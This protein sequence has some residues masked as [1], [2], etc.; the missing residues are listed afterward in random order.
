MRRTLSF[1]IVLMTLVSLGSCAVRQTVPRR[2]LTTASPESPGKFDHFST[3]QGQRVVGY[4]TTDGRLHRFWGWARLVG[5]TMVFHRPETRAAGLT[6]AQPAITERVPIAELESVRSEAID[7]LRTT[8]LIG[9]LAAVA[10]F[11]IGFGY[12]LSA[13]GS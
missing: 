12:Y 7:P 11:V 13:M 1:L 5:D 9:V 4:T 6:N 2:D 8:L 3:P 10:A